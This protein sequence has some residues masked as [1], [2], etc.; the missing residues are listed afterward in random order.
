MSRYPVNALCIG[1]PAD[2]LVIFTQ[3]P[4][5]QYRLPDPLS[6][7]DYAFDD[8]GPRSV[9][10]VCYEVDRLCCDGVMFYYARPAGTTA[11]QAM[12]QLLAG[13]RKPGATPCTA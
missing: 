8:L 4:W 12:R 3:Y 1:G 6:V 7:D 11:E 9:E 2:G 13:Y 10:V 5:F